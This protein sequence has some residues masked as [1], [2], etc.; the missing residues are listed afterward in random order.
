VCLPAL[1]RQL[2]S[3]PPLLGFCSDFDPPAVLRHYGRDGGLPAGAHA[4]LRARR[5]L[6]GLAAKAA[7]ARRANRAELLG[8]A[9]GG[10]SRADASSS[11]YSSASKMIQ[12]GAKAGSRAVIRASDKA[13]VAPSK[14]EWDAAG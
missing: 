2:P 9:K 10:A 1:A 14:E 7:A 6:A 4:S 5:I 11:A 13:G 3:L 12:T 8:K